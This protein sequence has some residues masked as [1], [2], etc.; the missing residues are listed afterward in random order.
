[1]ASWAASVL[2]LLNQNA[3]DHSTH[4]ASP[5]TQVSVVHDLGIAAQSSCAPLAFALEVSLSTTPDCQSRLCVLFASHVVA[6]ALAY[7][8]SVAA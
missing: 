7:D 1:M 5:R 2:K 3:A 4:L 6:V 8:C